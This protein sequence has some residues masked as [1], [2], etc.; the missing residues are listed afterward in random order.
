[1]YYPEDW[2]DTSTGQSYQAG[3]YDEN[4]QR[5]D[6]VSFQENGQYRNVLCH[7]PYCGQDTILNLDNTGASAINLQCPHCTAQMEIQ[8]ELDEIVQKDS[9]NQNRSTDS[10]ANTAA[11]KKK[12]R[13]TL[14]IVLAVLAVLYM[15]G[16]FSEDRSSG[17]GYSGSGTGQLQMTQSSSAT[18]YGQ[19]VYLEK[20]ADGVYR[21]AAD[22]A[23]AD[24][25]ITYDREY[26]SYYDPESD[27]YLWYNT[28]VT[29]AIWQYWYEGISSDYGD[30]G[31]ME[32]YD[33]GWFI[34]EA[35]GRWV[36]LPERY[37]TDRLWFIQ[38]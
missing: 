6:S 29:P 33:D 15:I 17:G 7:C 8:S 20:S 35:E 18:T 32:R 26:D 28:E 27:C 37:H 13:K 3:Y 16:R 12:R 30:Y 5:Y 1:M 24:K 4:G 10:G 31:W 38:N 11:P 22:S 34:E 36:K 25:T 14:W 19:T 23:R 2:T 21:V 9:T